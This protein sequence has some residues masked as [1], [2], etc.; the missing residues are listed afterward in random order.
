MTPRGLGQVLAIAIGAAAQAMLG[1]WALAVVAFVAGV[2]YRRDRWSSVRYALG[3]SLAGA[4]GL[5]WLAWTGHPVGEVRRVL[6][7]STGLPILTLAILLPGIVAL[8]AA[9]L[10]AAAGRRVLFS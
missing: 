7:E 4:A 5:G 10:G 6:V 9:H 3:I 2:I 1:W 8:A